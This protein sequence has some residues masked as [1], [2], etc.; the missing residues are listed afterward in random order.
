MPIYDY[1]CKQC[2]KQLELL[3]PINAL[4]PECSDCDT[5]M[6][7]QILFA[8]AVHGSMARGREQAMSSLPQPGHGKGCPCCS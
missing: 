5:R 4:P 2:G 8:P 6:K 3:Q 7:R 1:V